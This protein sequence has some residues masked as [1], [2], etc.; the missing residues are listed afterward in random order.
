MRLLILSDLHREFWRKHQVSFDTAASAPD[1]VVLAGDID[2]NGVRAVQWAEKSFDGI[3]V[4]YVHGNHEGYG[5][6][7]D[8]EIEK[9]RAASAATSNVTFLDCGEHIVGNVRFLGAALWTD[10]KLFGDDRRYFAMARAEEAMSDYRCIRLA[11][12]SYGRL[13]SKDTALFHEQQKSWIAE[14]LATRHDGP[15]V[16][17]THMAPSMRSVPTQ[18]ANDLLSSAYAS[19]L[20][21]VVE[22][23]DI[24][25]HGH[26][27]ESLDYKIGPCRV[28]CNPFGYMSRDGSQENERFDPNFIV[29]V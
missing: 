10:F 8:R 24:W 18:Y 9:I 15:T 20:D 22:K 28:V 13:R 2:T 3:P 7:L 14:K 11:S 27:H 4:I 21:E 29:E 17:V 5:H 19:N 1:A 12:K 6:N 23:A 26:M 16:V 25:V